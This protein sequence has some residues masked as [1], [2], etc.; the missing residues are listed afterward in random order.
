MVVFQKMFGKDH[1]KREFIK[2]RTSREQNN[3]SRENIDSGIISGKGPMCD[4]LTRFTY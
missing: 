1:K 4:K 2:D 3:F